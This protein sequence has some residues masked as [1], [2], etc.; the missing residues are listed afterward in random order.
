LE[1][2]V[3][4]EDAVR[5]TNAGE[6]ALGAAI[7]SRDIAGARRLA[8]RIRTG[9]VIINDL[10]VP[11]ADPRMPFGGVKASGFGTTRGDEGLREMTFPHVVAL[12][13]GR[14]RS[15]FHAPADRDAELFTSYIQATHGRHRFGAICELI[16]TLI[17]RSKRRTT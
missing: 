8:T 12:R 17:K 13:R 7:F 10:I 2:A 4:E 15:H 6:F 3:D 14:M 9:F 1:R 11:T 16:G 5:R